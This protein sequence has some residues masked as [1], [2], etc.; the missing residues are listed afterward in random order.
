MAE[1]ALVKVLSQALNRAGQV[2][3][4]LVAP[5]ALFLKRTNQ[6]YLGRKLEGVG[7][8]FKRQKN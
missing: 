6:D 4:G 7:V 2:L 5:A 1:S 3:P 8:L